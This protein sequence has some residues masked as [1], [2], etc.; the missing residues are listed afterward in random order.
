MVGSRGERG[1][2]ALLGPLRL[3]TPKGAS[4]CG[5]ESHPGVYRRDEPKVGLCGEDSDR[6][7]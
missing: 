4:L 5:G 2:V 1:E 3:E 7:Q 6:V